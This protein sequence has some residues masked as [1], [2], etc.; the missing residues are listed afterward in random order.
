VNPT[1]RRPL[2]HG[3][4]LLVV[5]T[6]AV[7]ACTQVAPPPP[8]ASSSASP[9]AS[10]SASPSASTAAVSPSPVATIVAS[11]SPSATPVPTICPI[12]EQKGNLPSDRLV[13]MKV[14]TSATADTLTFVFGRSSLGNPAGQPVGDLA[15]ATKPYTEGASGKPIRMDGDQVIQV[16][17]MHMSL[18][19][20]VGQETYQGPASVKP[21]LPAL[22]QA[23]LFDAFEGQMGYYIGFDGPGCVTLERVGQNVVLTFAH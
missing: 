11:G 6:L 22:R 16:R 4:G 18:Q 3:L 13:D 12:A 14:G 21:A 10:A 9:S 15:I 19:N 2:H 8:S 7:A 1:P 20:D 5:A 17:F 23:T